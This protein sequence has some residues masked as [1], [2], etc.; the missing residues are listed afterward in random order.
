MFILVVSAEVG[1]SMGLV[2]NVLPCSAGKIIVDG[3]ACNVVLE[4]RFSLEI[5]FAEYLRDGKFDMW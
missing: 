2:D 1:Y 3:N 5:V 4:A